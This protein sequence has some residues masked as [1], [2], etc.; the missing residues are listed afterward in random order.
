[1][2]NV[3]TNRIHLTL[4]QCNKSVLPLGVYK[5]ITYNSH[6]LRI[7]TA[8]V[9]FVLSMHICHKALTYYSVRRL[10]LIIVI[11]HVLIIEFCLFF[12]KLNDIRIRKDIFFFCKKKSCTAKYVYIWKNK[13]TF[14]LLFLQIDKSHFVGLV[15]KTFITVWPFIMM[16][17]HDLK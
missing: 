15:S 16:S 9:L 7:Q 11:Y 8:V 17:L 4:R 12:C 5:Y 2:I 6:V 3:F 1:M 10:I 13:K 14:N